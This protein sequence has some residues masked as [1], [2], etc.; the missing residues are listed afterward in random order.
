[1]ATAVRRHGA[2]RTCADR[3]FDL[4]PIL[5]R[6]RAQKDPAGLC[7]DTHA[8]KDTRLIKHPTHF[9]LIDP[10]RPRRWPPPPLVLGGHA[11]SLT[12]Y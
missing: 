11:A 8:R 4:F 1:M 5:G 9:I 7:G 12:P 2:R 3:P 6:E 10:P